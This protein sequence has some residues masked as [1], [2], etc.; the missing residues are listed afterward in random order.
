MVSGALVLWF[1]G[2]VGMKILAMLLFW[3]VSITSIRMDVTHP[4]FWFGGPFLLYSISG[5]LLF[6]LDIHPNK[7]WGGFLVSELDYGFAMNLQY[8][9]LLAS[10]LVI[11][12]ERMDLR[13]ALRDQKITH[14]FNGVLPVLALTII[15]SGFA[16]SEIILQGF[17][18]KIDV[19]LY[20]SWATRFSFALNMVS[21]CVGVFL[22]KQFV[23]RKPLRA[24]AAIACFIVLGVT[25]VLLSGQRN[26]MFRVLIVVLFSIHISYHKISLR[27]FL[28]LF[29]ATTPLI[30]IL[31]GFKMAG[32][33]GNSAASYFSIFENIVNIANF[34]ENLGLM[35]ESP[36]ILYG[37]FLLFLILGDE[38]R[39]AGDNL[40]MLVTRMPVDVPFQNGVTLINDLIT[41]VSP[42]FLKLHANSSTYFYNEMVF[43]VNTSKG[44]G[45]GFSL[46][47][48]GYLNFGVA[49]AILIMLVFGA[50]VRFVY[51]RAAKSAL[52]LFFFIGFL[53]I[54]FAASRN[55]LTMP[56]SQ[57]LKHVLLPLAAMI[58][59]SYLMGRSARPA[60]PG[61]ARR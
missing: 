34:A 25:V 61:G 43:P 22:I 50:A 21:T 28:I 59:I 60:L 35:G 6:I 2:D 26:F 15:L 8:M 30:L 41:A 4:F 57:G 46:V 29:L 9:G 55:D 42:G 44:G 33:A 3:L 58:L 36:I 38:F 14:F 39:T 56:I 16:I 13:A 11:G 51:R 45:Q 31:G 37:K 49:G 5:P 20:G 27:N 17:T 24:F 7:V 10:S 12:P 23:E 1:P 40:A 47:G 18:Q 48:A 54:S 52:G 32:I 53:P 19:V